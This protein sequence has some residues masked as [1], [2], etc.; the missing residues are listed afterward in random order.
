VYRS[1]TALTASLIDD[2][3]GKTILSQRLKEKN[4]AAATT[5]GTNIARQAM[6]KKITKVVFDRGGYQYHGTIKALA[7]SA[8][9]GGLEF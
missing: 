5:L 8:R 1:N 3:A 9:K 6:Q 4:T 2:T 7:E